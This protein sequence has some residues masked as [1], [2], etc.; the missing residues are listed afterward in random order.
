TPRTLATLTRRKQDLEVEMTISRRSCKFSRLYPQGEIDA[1]SEGFER[2]AGA[3]TYER[4]NPL[5]RLQSPA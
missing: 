5:G 2:T 1:G 3:N 4:Q